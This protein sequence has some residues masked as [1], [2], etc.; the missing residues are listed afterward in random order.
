MHFHYIIRFKGG[1]HPTPKGKAAIKFRVLT[2]F[3][4]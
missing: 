2:K 1:G 3:L 4:L